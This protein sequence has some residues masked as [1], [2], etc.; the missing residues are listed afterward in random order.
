MNNNIKLIAIVAVVILLAGGL[1]FVFRNKAITTN[2]PQ[3]QEQNQKQNGRK[4]PID[5]QTPQAVDHSATDKS[6]LTA[7]EVAKHTT[8]KDCWTIVEGNV[9]DITP[10]IPNH[11]G[12]KAN[13][14][15]ACGTDATA[16]FTT[17]AGR[18]HSQ[19]A[20]DLLQNY[21]VGSVVTENVQN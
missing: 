4:Q 17:S 21:L 11:P 10:Y 13:I 3:N 1:F 16:M 12:G 2:G 19:R 14:M 5:R 15:R 9:Y 8:D 20:Q 6:T 18:A 7:T